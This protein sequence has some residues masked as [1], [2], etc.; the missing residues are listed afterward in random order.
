MDRVKAGSP[1]N[2]RRIAREL[3]T[4]RAMI[5]IY[6]HD[7]H[8]GA[9]QRCAECSALWD[10]AHARVDHCPF[11]DDKPTCINCAVHCY[12]QTAREQIRVVMR[13]AGPRMPWRH[14]VLTFWHIVNGKKAAPTHSRRAD[15]ARP[16]R[17]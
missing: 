8:G 13:H 6:C 3:K 7:L 1:A 12:K 4:V 17:H 16:S 11:L 2:Q 10:Y 15:P 5:G 9:D 14:P